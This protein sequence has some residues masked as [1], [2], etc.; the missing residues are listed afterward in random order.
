MNK[1]AI[2]FLL[3]FM[4]IYQPATADKSGTDRRGVVIN[5]EEQYSVV[6]NHE[7]QYS[8]WQKGHKLPSGW[9]AVGFVGN[10]DKALQYIDKVGAEKNPKINR[11]QDALRIYEELQ[12]K[13]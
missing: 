12:Q 1:T 8:I 9:R 13:K 2:F 4:G 3:L 7:E 6:I 11:R 5:H 10:K